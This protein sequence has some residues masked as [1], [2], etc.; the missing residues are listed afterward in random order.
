MRFNS[1]NHVACFTNQI[2]SFVDQPWPASKDEQQRANQT[3]ESR[4]FGL[5]VGLR[6]DL[7]MP[8]LLL[9]PHHLP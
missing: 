5:S 3:L 8:P 4:S 1:R 7:R 2:V 9:L 6:A